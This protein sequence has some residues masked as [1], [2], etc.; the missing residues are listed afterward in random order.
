MNIPRRL[1]IAITIAAAF[2][3]SAAAQQPTPQAKL[4]AA[5]P[6]IEQPATPQAHQQMPVEA[7]CRAP[8]LDRYPKDE[9]RPLPNNQAPPDLHI[10]SQL[11]RAK[12]CRLG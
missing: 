4:S 7:A 5:E 9:L 12:I 6:R 2:A 3:S 10:P 8:R 11:G 1:L